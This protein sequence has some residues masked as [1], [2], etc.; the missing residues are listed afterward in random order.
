MP[1]GEEASMLG[2]I[3]DITAALRGSGC[4]M[5]QQFHLVEGGSQGVSYPLTSPTL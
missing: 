4:G 1:S 5:L 2:R 3:E